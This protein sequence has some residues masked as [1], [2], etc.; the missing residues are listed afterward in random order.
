M[1]PT[2]WTRKSLVLAVGVVALA[3]AFGFAAFGLS[4]PEPVASAALGPDWY[5]SRLAFVFTTCS[6]IKHTRSVVSVRVAKVPM[7][8]RLRI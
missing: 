1:F 2:W 8:G 5:C 7:C 6:R 3:C 4:A